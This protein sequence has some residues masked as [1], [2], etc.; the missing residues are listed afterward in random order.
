MLSSFF[1]LFEDL[2]LTAILSVNTVTS[3]VEF[4][5]FR[6]EVITGFQR[7]LLLFIAGDALT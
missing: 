3:E 7:C 6:F 2:G 5:T 1:A 4:D